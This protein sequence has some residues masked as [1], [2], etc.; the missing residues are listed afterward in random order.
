MSLAVS[1]ARRVYRRGRA[2]RTDRGDV[3]ALA[4][5]DLDVGDGE[6]VVVVGPSGSGKSTLLRSVAGL[7]PL[8][9]GRVVIGGSDVT[10][11]PPGR[12]NVAMVFQDYA[13]LPHLTVGD[14]IGFG[15]R[16][17]GT[18]RDD[19]RRKVADA[20]RILGLDEMLDRRPRQLSGGEQQRVALARAIVRDPAAFLMDEPLSSLDA[21]LRLRTRGEIRA[22]QRRLGVAMLYVTH[23]Q[24]EAMGL[25]DRIVI[26]RDGVVEQAGTPDEVF[27]KPANVFVARFFG[28]LP[29]NLLTDGGAHGGVQTIGVRPERVR[30]TPQGSGRRDG[31]VDAVEPAGEEAV[32]RLSGVTG[33]R[34]SVLARVSWSERPLPGTRVGLAWEGSDE[35]RFAGTGQR[36]P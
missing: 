10:D 29:M 18:N 27:S 20:A 7:E 21:D 4:G 1:D 5:V 14:N 12:R 33:A 17:R 6:L 2:G 9:S 22:L 25:A 23:D 28:T 31:T 34:D 19:V 36:L 26:L 30:L 8:D 11:E 3:V 15:E 24:I 32:V 35:H 13:L 16:A